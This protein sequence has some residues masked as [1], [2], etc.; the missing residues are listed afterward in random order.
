MGRVTHEEHGVVTPMR[1][2]LHDLNYLKAIKS[3]LVTCVPS[4]EARIRNS[5]ESSKLTQEA[6]TQ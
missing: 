1:F 5:A 2:D 4:W 3:P 6:H